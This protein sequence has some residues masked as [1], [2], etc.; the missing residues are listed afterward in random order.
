MSKPARYLIE[1]RT[2]TQ[3]PVS[4]ARLQRWVES[5]KLPLRLKIRRA[6]DGRVLRV[7]EALGIEAHAPKKTRKRPDTRRASGRLR[8]S[9][10]AARVKPESAELEPISEPKSATQTTSSKK[11]SARIPKKTSAK[12]PKTP[13]AKIS[14]KGSGKVPKKGSG[15]IA[16]APAKSGGSGKKIPKSSKRLR[17]SARKRTA[18]GVPAS[19]PSIRSPLVASLCL[20]I[21]TLGGV[22]HGVFGAAPAS[23]RHAAKGRALAALVETL[24]P[25]GFGLLGGIACIGAW[26]WLAARLRQRRLAAEAE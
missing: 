14:K 2:G 16:Q 13:S 18:R 6:G 20:P 11:T 9:G 19:A 5:G 3:G 8:R 17:A 7:A 10:R 23:G 4:K 12:A 24:G 22:L 21:L 26:L 1:T 15:K 25:V